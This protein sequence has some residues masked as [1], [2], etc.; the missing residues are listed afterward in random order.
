MLIT[1]TKFTE[2]AIVYAECAGLKMLSWDYP[3]KE[4]LFT[5]IGETGLHPITCLTT[6]SKNEK[7]RLLEDKVILCQ[8]IKRDQTSLKKQGISDQKIA[9]IIEET[10][11]LCQ[12]GAG[13]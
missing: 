3:Q 8:D 10:G 6:L 7:R 11:A 5:L 4:N 9:R 13:V 2:N 12:P 1:N